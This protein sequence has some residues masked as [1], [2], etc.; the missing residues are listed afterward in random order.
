MHQAHQVHCLR[1]VCIH[2]VAQQGQH[3]RVTGWGCRAQ[4]VDQPLQCQQD[5]WGHRA[6]AKEQRVRS[7]LGV[8]SLQLHGCMS[9]QR[10]PCLNVGERPDATCHQLDQC[11]FNPLHIVRATSI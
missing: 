11:D 1:L 6:W 10:T 2:G 7:R 8:A 4:R 9:T 5:L 3:Q